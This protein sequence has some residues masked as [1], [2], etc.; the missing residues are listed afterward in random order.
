M[1]TTDVTA[2]VGYLH[3]LFV[4][5]CFSMKHWDCALRAKVGT[6]WTLDSGSPTGMVCFI[7]ICASLSVCVPN[8][9]AGR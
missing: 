9:V 2:V 7:L 4:Y 1:S 5:S 8:S 3:A 6:W